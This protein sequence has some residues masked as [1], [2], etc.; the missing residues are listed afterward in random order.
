[1][2]HGPRLFWLAAFILLPTHDALGQGIG[3]RLSL[4][5]APPSPAALGQAVT[6]A[7]RPAAAGT[8]YRYTATMLATGTGLLTMGTSCIAP[9]NIGF[10]S[11][12]S[13]TPAS[14]GYR[15]T[16]HSVR[17]LTAHDSVSVSYQ[18]D[19]PTGGFLN[20]NVVQPPNPQPPGQLLLTVRTNDRGSG[21]RYQWVVRFSPAPGAVPHPIV[22]WT[23]ESSAPV[24]SV[25]LVLP[26]GTYVASARVGIHHGD[27]CQ[28]AETSSGAI[29][30][31]VIH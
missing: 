9:R 30:S 13:W 1:V 12:V 19:A 7:V 23:G 2:T 25:P 31:Q 10:G 5:V 18:V 27:A 28:I 3:A 20:L 26:P 16:V 11:R 17:S 8:K 22:N 24:H 21:A 4:G 14:G 6:L 15:L 29:G